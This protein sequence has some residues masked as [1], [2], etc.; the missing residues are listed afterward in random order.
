[1]DLWAGLRKR[2]QAGKGRGREVVWG[3][4]DSR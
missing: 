4:R 1:M 2:G 3:D